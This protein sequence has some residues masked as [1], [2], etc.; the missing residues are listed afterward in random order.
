MRI[1]G[2]THEDDPWGLLDPRINRNPKT[3]VINA[4]MNKMAAPIVEMSF[5]FSLLIFL[6]LSFLVLENNRFCMCTLIF[7]LKV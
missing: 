5:I 3:I 2:V 1:P 4:I 7:P 6:S